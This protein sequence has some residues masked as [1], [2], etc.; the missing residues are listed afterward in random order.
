MWITTRFGHT[1]EKGSE[2]VEKFRRQLASERYVQLRTKIET[3][4]TM[5]VESRMD[6]KQLSQAGDK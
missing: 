1:E 4:P 3:K 2:S 6:V 5:S